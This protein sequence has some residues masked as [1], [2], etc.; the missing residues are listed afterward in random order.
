MHAISSKWKYIL[1]LWKVGIFDIF[2]FAS[3]SASSG[4]YKFKNTWGCKDIFYYE[5]YHQSLTSEPSKTLENVL[6]L[7][8]EDWRRFQQSACN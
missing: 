6:L 4:F 1:I 8:R 5:I 3:I 2:Q 7:R